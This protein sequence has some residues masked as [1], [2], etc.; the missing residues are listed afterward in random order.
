MLK[1]NNIWLAYSVSRGPGWEMFYEPSQLVDVGAEKP[2]YDI[3][4]GIVGV[5]E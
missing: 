2:T 5:G 1:D 3:W 4:R